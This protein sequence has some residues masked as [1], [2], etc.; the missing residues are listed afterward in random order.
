MITPR[1][2]LPPGAMRLTRPHLI[3]FLIFFGIRHLVGL[4][5]FLFIAVTAFQADMAPIGYLMLVLT[6]AY[7]T[8]A[9]ISALKLWRQFQ[10]MNQARNSEDKKNASH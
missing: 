10:K 1:R 7:A 5:V 3:R 9:C 4:A 6:P 8:F 2:S